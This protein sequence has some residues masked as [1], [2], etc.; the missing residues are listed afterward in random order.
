MSRSQ[1]SIILGR[2]STELLNIIHLEMLC[3]IVTVQVHQLDH[4]DIFHKRKADYPQET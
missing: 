2:Y 1:V 3:G 4:S